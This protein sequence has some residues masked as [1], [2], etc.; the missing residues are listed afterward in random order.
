[1]ALKLAVISVEGVATAE[2]REVLAHAGIAAEG[3]CS[4]AGTDAVGSHG[5]PEHRL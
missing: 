3:R 4:A 1:V 5:L 2:G